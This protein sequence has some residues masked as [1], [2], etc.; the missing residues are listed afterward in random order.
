MNNRKKISILTPC[1]NEEGNITNIYHAIRNIFGKKLSSYDYEIIFIDNFSTDTTRILIREIC[2]RDTKVK[3]IFNIR[4]FG[5]ATSSYYGLCQTTG[6]C[7]VLLAADF[8]EPVELIPSFVSEWEKGYKLVVGIKHKSKENPIKRLLRTLYYKLFKKISEDVDQIEHFD[9]FGLY[10]KS[11]VDILRSLHEPT[12]YIKSIVA[13]FGFKHKHILYTQEKR[14]SGRTHLSWYELYNDAMLTFTTYT[15]IGPRI[16]TIFGFIGSFISFIC[17][18]YYLII[19]LI[20]WDSFVM[21]QAP[22]IIGM[23]FLGALQL[24]FIG[25]LGEYV[26]SINSRVMNRPLVIEEERINFDQD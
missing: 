9:G 7:A 16:A 15:K 20:F 22:L 10:D 6:D 17:A 1:Y 21:G 11:F 2:D 13:E 25:L 5:S 23:F 24:F 26:M 19:K 14:M 8:Q 18:F 4:N 12:P 3:A